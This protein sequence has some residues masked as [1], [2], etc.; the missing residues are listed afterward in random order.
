MRSSNACAQLIGH[1]LPAEPER[2][3][4][5]DASQPAAA[6]LACAV[7]AVTALM[8]GQTA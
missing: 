8:A 1:A 5:I 7:A 3:C 4:V 6:V 2:F